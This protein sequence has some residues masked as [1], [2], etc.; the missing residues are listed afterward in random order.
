MTDERRKNKAT[1][2]YEDEDDEFADHVT[3]HDRVFDD[4]RLPNRLSELLFEVLEEE[5]VS[6]KQFT[7]AAVQFIMKG[8]SGNVK[9]ISKDDT[10]KAFKNKEVEPSNMNVEP[11][12]AD[13]GVCGYNKTLANIAFSPLIQS[14]G[15]S[16]W[17]YKIIKCIPYCYPLRHRNED[18]NVSGNDDHRNNVLATT[19]LGLL[20]NN[21]VTFG[22]NFPK[23]KQ[24]AP[25][26]EIPLFMDD[27][28]DDVKRII[29]DRARIVR[30]N[31][32]RST[33]CYVKEPSQNV[34]VEK[35]GEKKKRKKRSKVVTEELVTA[36]ESK[37]K[38]RVAKSKGKTIATSSNIASDS[39]A[40]EEVNEDGRKK[41]LRL[42]TNKTPI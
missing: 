33:G 38:K 13:I 39:S 1:T 27:V 30:S 8:V 41:R 6:M 12:M 32:N 29:L 7:T 21:N 22:V 28:V 5:G 16:K 42:A 37:K 23:K 34:V 4:N 2:V 24:G 25:A 26:D 36:T 18:L 40:G 31:Y 15:F 3:I 19:I 17:V 35:V 14:K 10:S 20:W 11:T 9:A